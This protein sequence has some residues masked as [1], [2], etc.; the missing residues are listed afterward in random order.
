MRCPLGVIDAEGPNLINVS[1]KKERKKVR[2]ERSTGRMDVARKSTCSE[3]QNC[4]GTAMWLCLSLI[5]Q[6]RRWRGR[7][8]NASYIGILPLNSRVHLLI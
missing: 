4:R 7:T 5:I 3:G 1:S 6:Q 2:R 8:V